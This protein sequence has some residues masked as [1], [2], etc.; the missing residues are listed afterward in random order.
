M[1]IKDDGKNRW[2]VTNEDGVEVSVMRNNHDQY[3]FMAGGAITAIDGVMAEAL[4]Y[5]AKEERL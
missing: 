2:T 5:L 3:L 4:L 1:D